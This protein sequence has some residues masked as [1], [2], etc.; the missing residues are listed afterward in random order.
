V[1][2]GFRAARKHFVAESG[3]A[4]RLVEK[5][6]P[7]PATS[8]KDLNMT[9]TKNH[10]IS[11]ALS[12]A[13]GCGVL[14]LSLSLPNIARADTALSVADIAAADG[15]V[16]LEDTVMAQAWMKPGVDLSTYDS[17][18]VLPTTIKP[19]K[20]RG[21]G[22][23]YALTEAQLKYL[24]EVVPREVTDELSELTSLRLTDQRA[25]K[26]LVLEVAV[27]DVVS[28]VPPQSTG[29]GATFTRLLGSATV[30][31]ELRD[32][33]TND[34]VARA[35]ER[36]QVEYRT[37]HRSNRAWDQAEARRAAERFGEDVKAQIEEFTAAPV[38]A[39]ASN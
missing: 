39:V 5:F 37:L 31:I 19:G 33:T 7:P 6:T 36:R 2:P 14:L 16:P 30:A 12:A 11:F 21:I 8:R 26:G 32:A 9:T 25:P 3:A 10:R 38:R 24:C 13:I 28:H 27:V 1:I 29:R 18:I 4:G 34:V 35:V 17:L 20:V 23:D 15:L 22:N